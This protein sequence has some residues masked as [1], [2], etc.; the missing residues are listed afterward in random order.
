[1]TAISR[2]VLTS[3]LT[4]ARASAKLQVDGDGVSPRLK[5]IEAEL[6]AAS[7]DARRSTVD[8]T[9]RSSMAAPETTAELESFTA[10][11]RLPGNPEPA[12]KAALA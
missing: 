8:S 9:A 2:E 1:V 4:W 6:A 3:I 5:V 12:G 10:P 7:L 11:T